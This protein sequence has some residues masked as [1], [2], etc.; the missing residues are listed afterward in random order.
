V[1]TPL[2]ELTPVVL[3]RTVNSDIVPLVG[4]M[5]P[6]CPV[7]AACV[8][9][10]VP[11][12]RPNISNVADDVAVPEQNV[13]KVRKLGSTVGMQVVQSFPDELMTW[14]DPT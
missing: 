7:P 9:V 4:I 2:D 10:V 6:N 1:N 11:V 5:K 8:Q 3:H 12:P 13:L 14:V